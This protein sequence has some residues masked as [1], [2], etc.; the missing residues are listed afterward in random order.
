MRIYNYSIRSV[1]IG[2]IVAVCPRLRSL[3]LYCSWEEEPKFDWTT[4][5]D[6]Q[7]LQS[8]SVDLHHGGPGIDLQLQ[9]VH[10]L[11]MH[12][13]NLNEVSLYIGDSLCFLI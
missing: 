12:L 5:A 11:V 10:G 13:P 8:I 2:H 1:E 6:H 9:P 4:M 7:Q 3:Q